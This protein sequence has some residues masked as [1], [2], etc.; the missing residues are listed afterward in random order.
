MLSRL[1]SLGSLSLLLTADALPAA[2]P[3]APRPNVIIL[4][5]DD[6]GYG[7]LACF[8]HATF[9][10][11]HL[12]RFPTPARVRRFHAKSFR[13]AIDND[14]IGVRFGGQRVGDNAFALEGLGAD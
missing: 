13:R 5:A 2:D 8:G 9:K 4:L 7:E 10:T 14:P 12:D 3:P 6:L 11:P 1:L